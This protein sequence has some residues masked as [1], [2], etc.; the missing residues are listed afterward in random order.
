M[1]HICIDGENS[2][3]S[4]YNSQT[5]KCSQK[6][7]TDQHLLNSDFL[8][9]NYL[10]L[11]PVDTIGD[12]DL[13]ISFK[14]TNESQLDNKS[15]DCENF[16]DRN[17]FNK[18]NNKCDSVL[19]KT[20]SLTQ[21][22]KISNQTPSSV[23]EKD[24]YE[25]CVDDSFSDDNSKF[26]HQ[27]L[28]RDTCETLIKTNPTHKEVRNI[29]TTQV[30][31][32]N[33]LEDI[34]PTNSRNVLDQNYVD[35]QDSTSDSIKTGSTVVAVAVSEPCLNM[36][37]PEYHICLDSKFDDELKSYDQT[38]DSGGDEFFLVQYPPQSSKSLSEPNVL[39]SVDISRSPGKR[40]FKKCLEEYYNDYEDCL[41]AYGIYQKGMQEKTEEGT[42]EMS[43]DEIFN[44]ILLPFK[45]KSA[46]DV[47]DR[48]F[49]MLTY[50]PGPSKN[51]RQSAF[52][53]GYQCDER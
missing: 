41:E 10:N 40:C 47:M 48:S 6:K 3:N 1:V 35:V 5:D 42:V 31:E 27:Q 2:F 21:S 29:Q 28:N 11:K 17:V 33:E 45:S 15:G 16:N 36:N 25:T 53:P 51:R 39:D 26:N 23:S 14:S 24:G 18:N 49:I 12:S 34:T 37:F 52:V 9:N 8:E 30:L 7:N 32:E 13:D 20:D 19:I 43:D 22:E 46:P 44:D 50:D 38:E 4:S